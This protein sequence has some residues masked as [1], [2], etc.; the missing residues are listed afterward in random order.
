MLAVDGLGGGSLVLFW[1]VLAASMPMPAAAAPSA[2]GGLGGD[3]G[4]LQPVSKLLTNAAKPAAIPAKDGLNLGYQEG[5][6]QGVVWVFGIGDQRRMCK[7][8]FVDDVFDVSL[9]NQ[10]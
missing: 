8:T 1:A 4:V 3:G 5:F 10:F 6:I 9:P 2:A 7:D